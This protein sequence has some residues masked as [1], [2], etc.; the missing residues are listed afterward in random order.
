MSYIKVRLKVN[1][2]N[3]M[4]YGD[5][6]VIGKK[7]YPSSLS[8]LVFN[9]IHTVEYFCQVICLYPGRSKQYIDQDISYLSYLDSHGA[10]GLSVSLYHETI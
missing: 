7:V 2:L 6:Q 1:R 10:T 8:S 3:P 4:T 9:K 5:I